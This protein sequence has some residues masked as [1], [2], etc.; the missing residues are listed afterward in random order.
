MNQPKQP[1]LFYYTGALDHVL[2]H[3]QTKDSPFDCVDFWNCS[4][5]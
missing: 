1:E 5:E 4:L 2:K 3:T